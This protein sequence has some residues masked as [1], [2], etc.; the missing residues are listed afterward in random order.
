VTSVAA[1]GV[2]VVTATMVVDQSVTN[3]TGLATLHASVVRR[4]IGATSVTA[5]AISLETVARK[6]IPA[7]TATRL[8]TW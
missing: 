8:A 1:A 2:N 7:T 4:R 5:P 3:A 6:R